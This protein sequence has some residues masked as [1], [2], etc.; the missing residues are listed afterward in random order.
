MRFAKIRAQPY[1]SVFVHRFGRSRKY[2]RLPLLEPL[3][4]P[5]R[6]VPLPVL[7]GPLG[8]ATGWIY[9]S[10]LR[11]SGLLGHGVQLPLSRYALQR[12][13]A[14]L[15]ELDARPR[16]QVGDGARDQHLAGRRRRS[17]AG[18][19]VTAMPRTSPFVTSTSPV[20]RPAS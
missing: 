6:H 2:R 15:S 7:M 17:D 1:G 11:I 20:W 12:M 14:A 13:G 19:D 8:E 4:A 5:S 18:A 10:P 9:R 16:D 3:T